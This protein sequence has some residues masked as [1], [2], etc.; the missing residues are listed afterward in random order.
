MVKLERAAEL[1]AKFSPYLC[2]QSEHRWIRQKG[3]HAFRPLRQHLI[4]V[5]RR[6][7]HREKDLKNKLVRHVLMEQIA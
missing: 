6:H 1:L 3:P 5:S 4:G 7:R 2:Q